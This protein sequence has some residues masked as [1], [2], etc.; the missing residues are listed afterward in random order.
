[1]SQGDSQN[2]SGPAGAWRRL[3]AP[4]AVPR[5]CNAGQPRQGRRETVVATTRNSY[6]Y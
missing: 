6:V 3:G 1:M 5:G 2:A 4:A